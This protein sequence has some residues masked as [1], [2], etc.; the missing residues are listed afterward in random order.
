MGFEYTIRFALP[1][2]FSLASLAA[3]LPPP[4]VPDSSWPAYDVSL[5]PDGVIFVDHGRSA[6]AATA[7]RALVDEALRHSRSVVI[8]EA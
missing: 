3:R 2:D 6:V 8:E 1:K 4:A 7:F 5:A